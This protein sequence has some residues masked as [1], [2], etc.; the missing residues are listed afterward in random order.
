MPAI[1]KPLGKFAQTRL[2]RASWKVNRATP[3]RIKIRDSQR[4]AEKGVRLPIA[5]DHTTS[6]RGTG[7][8]ST[9]M[10]REYTRA[11]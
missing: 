11:D 3:P 7:R 5:R 10:T 6:R 4:R 2:K 1:V 8:P 9:V